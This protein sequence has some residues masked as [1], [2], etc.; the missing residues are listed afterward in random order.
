M[1]KKWEGSS[2]PAFSKMCNFSWVHYFQ[3]CGSGF[4]ET[5]SGNG[6]GSS[7]TRIQGFDDQKTK[8]KIIQRKFC[9]IFFQYKFALAPA[10]VQWILQPSK[11]N[12]EHF[13]KLNLST[14]FLCL[15]LIFALLD[16]DRES[17]SGSRDPTESGFHLDPIRIHNT[18]F[19][20][21]LGKSGLIWIYMRWP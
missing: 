13:K 20:F 17:G 4:I 14:F 21:V 16:P 8:R 2:R 15:W 19:I 7:I 12:I 9:L 18:E 3:R 5:G 11:E 6:S 10:T 1:T